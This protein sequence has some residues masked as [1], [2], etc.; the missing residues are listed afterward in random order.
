MPWAQQRL[1]AE[2]AWSMSKGEG[3][4]VAVVDT[5]VDA[6]TPQL[7]GRVLRGIDLTSA[8]R[9]RADSDCFGHGTF[10][11]GI[12]AAAPSDG[13]G[14][15][16]VAPEARILPI[17]VATT[18]N[19]GTASRLAQ[20][21]RLAADAGADV[22]NVSASTAAPE[23]ALVAAVAYAEAK[24]VVVVAAAANGAQEGAGPAYPA[25]LPTVL[26][27][28]AIDA[29]GKRASFSQTG[30]HLA[31][32]APGADVVSIGPRGPGHW[33]GSGTSYAVPIVV[34]TAALVRSYRPGLSAAQVRHR[35]LITADHPAANLPDPRYG[36]G[37]VNPA[38]ALSAV[39]PEESG[40]SAAPHPALV[41][42]PELSPRDAIGPVVAAV[43]AGILVV[44]VG[45]V[46]CLRLL[47]PAGRRRHWQPARSVDRR[48]G[49]R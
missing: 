38:A 42:R 49:I 12:I 35:L 43:G 31:L 37:E 9:G 11:A 26:A 48:D 13:S 23:P 30:E 8:G 44:L 34:G 17:R 5:G 47:L 32:V 33:K 16:G 7:R 25:A 19:D 40:T 20:G 4:V 2:R 21:I 22:I 10:I 39:L 6:V 27:V 1:G 3:V 18:M 46:L 28:G 45:I 24:N 15:T 36:W 41:R 14:F 29:T